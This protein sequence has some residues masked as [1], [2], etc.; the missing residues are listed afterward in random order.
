MDAIL[1]PIERV[2]DAITWFL[3]ATEQRV[4]YVQ[5]SEALRLPIVAKLASLEAHPR[6]RRAVVVLEAGVEPDDD[7]W[8][9]RAEELEQALAQA[10]ER[11]AAADPPLAIRPLGPLV[12]ASTPG[13]AF[14]RLL[15]A[16]L[17]AVQPPLEGL[18]VVLAP[19]WVNDADLWRGS[20]APL[21]SR[22]ELAGARFVVVDPEDGPARPVAQQMGPRAELVDGRIDDGAVKKA[23]STMVAAMASAPAGADAARA[24]GLAGPREAP[25]RRLKAPAPLTAEQ[26]QRA[27]AEVGLAPAYAQ[28]D[29]MQRIRV[30]VM[31]A[32]EAMGQGRAVDAVRLQREARDLAAQAGL[33]R[34]PVLFEIMMGAYA[35]QGGAPQHALGAFDSAAA[36]AEQRNLP[37]LGAQALLAKGGALL[38]LKNPDQAAVAYAEAGRVAGARAAALA[39]EGYRMS[40]TLLAGMRRDQQAIAVWQRALEIAGGMPPEDRKA[41]TAADVARA[42]A[43]ACRKHGLR[44]QAEALEAQAA[45]LEAPPEPRTEAG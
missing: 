4:L 11:A 42:L 35:L 44:A 34:E 38:T 29:V 7:G 23:M 2:Q 12:G 18:L 33:V 6:C 10:R 21:L 24:A 3:A 30:A 5:A 1:K 19:A 28:P 32:A 25:P 15:R 13:A 22:P 16:A 27:M 20:L 41:T 45:A 37:E 36:L 8:A 40:G 9:T 26:R 14:A 39:I 31:Q 43:G 17:D